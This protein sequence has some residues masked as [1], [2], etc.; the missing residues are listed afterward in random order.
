MVKGNEA[1]AFIKGTYV[2]EVLGIT[3]VWAV[4]YFGLDDVM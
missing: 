1:A 3:L 2:A 4:E